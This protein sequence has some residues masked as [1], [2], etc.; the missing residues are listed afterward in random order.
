MIFGSEERIREV[1]SEV[2]SRYRAIAVITS[3]VP[4]LIGEDQQMLRD[5]YAEIVV[6]AAGFL[7]H[8]EE[9]Y[10]AALDALRCRTDSGVYG[11]NIDG[12]NPI[13][14]F[15]FG[16]LREAERLLARVRLPT[17]TRFCAGSLDSVY[18]ASPD[19]L[20]TN[21]DL[22]S[23]V[24][25]P[26][27][28]LLGLEETGKAFSALHLKHSDMDLDPLMRELR[29]TEE[30][31][32][33]ACDKF[34]RRHDPPS[35]LIF[36]GASY[37]LFAAATLHRYLDAEII[38]IGSRNRKIPSPYPLTC[39]GGLREIEDCIRREEPDLV[40]GSSYEQSVCGT[41]AFVPFTFPLRGRFALRTRAL[42]GPEGVLSLMDE[43]LNACMDRNML[44]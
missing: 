10:L 18:H 13:D 17:S 38:A 8:F 40:L 30:R 24:G 42:A 26:V 15:Y 19:T 35:T 7:G 39:M 11:A 5:R 6:D 27:G 25:D 21:P 20:S 14:P 4:S 29:E 44:R 41:S 34:L 37:A 23:K 32:V 9:G 22:A 1:V 12:L 16:N 36:G 2:R 31:I 43:V 28:S 33:R 3:C